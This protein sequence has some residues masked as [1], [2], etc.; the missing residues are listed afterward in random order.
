[1]CAEIQA[2]LYLMC[3]WLL[4]DCNQNKTVQHTSVKLPSI[5]CNEN[6]SAVLELIQAKREKT[7]MAKPKGAILQSFPCEGAENTVK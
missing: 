2:G 4:S 6:H 3:L 1:V 7:N 5:K